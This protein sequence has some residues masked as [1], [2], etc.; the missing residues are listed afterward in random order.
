MSALDKIYNASYNE[1]GKMLTKGEVSIKQLKRFYTSQRRIA[2]DRY[3]KINVE[4]VRKEYGYTGKE[5]FS[6]LKNLVTT[7]DLLHA[8]IDV[9]KFFSSGASTKTELRLR[10]EKYIEKAKEN[11]LP[12]NN[13]NY[14]KWIRFIDWFSNSI[15]AKYFDSESEE[16]A[17]VFEEG[18]SPT[19][20]ERLILEL[21]EDEY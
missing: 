21:E 11:N 10:K 16:I 14:G 8:I 12:V 9:M 3:R 18:N 15:Y 20:W 6:P 13:N 7:S 1:L 5:Y 4:T 2:V 19:D 17:E